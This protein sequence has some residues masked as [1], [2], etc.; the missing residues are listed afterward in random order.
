MVYWPIVGFLWMVTRVYFR[1]IEVTGLEHVPEK[2]AVIFVGNH[3]NSLVDPVMLFTNCTRR[4]SFAAKDTL[5]KNPLVRFLFGVMG[6]VPIKRKQDHPDA[7]VDNSAA[8]EALFNL[9]R[10]EAAFGIFPEGISY[11]RP[12]MAPLKSGA[13]RIAIGAKREGIDVA[14]VPC[15]LSYRKRNRLRSRVL[16]QFG[17]PLYVDEALLEG[18][19]RE[20]ARA[21]TDDIERLLR[22]LTINAEDFE[23]LRVLDGVRRL[24]RPKGHSLSLQEQAEITRRFVDHY[25]RLKD[26]PE[27]KALYE[28]VL[29]YQNQLDAISFNDRD[30]LKPLSKWLWFTKALRHFFFMFV[31]LPLALP[32][33]LV[34]APVLLLTLAAGGA[35][36]KLLGRKDIVATT[37]MASATALVIFIYGLIQCLIFW[38]VPFPKSSWIGLL[39]LLGLLV[40][41]W[42]LIHVLERQSQLRNAVATLRKMVH[43]R[44]VL[45]DLRQRRESLRERILMLIDKYIDDD[46]DRIIEDPS[47]NKKD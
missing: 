42:A 22:S 19:D 43:L 17:E 14:I 40:S 27:I 26:V 46:I 6:C 36:S 20:Q 41:G 24:Y 21:L 35:G 5:F 2:G 33:A 18:D 8:F 15:G 30:L 4:T 32:G 16:V 31:L 9:L 1:R 23:T 44:D 10:G 38:F 25:E 39:V 47:G 12:E 3:P 34:H 45:R 11:T 13:A 28:D 7:K 37:K 29:D